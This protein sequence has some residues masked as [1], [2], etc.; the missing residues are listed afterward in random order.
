MATI[1]NRMK[2]ALVIT[3]KGYTYPLISPGGTAEI[4]DE[5]ARDWMSRANILTASGVD[6]DLST[7]EVKF[8]DLHWR[9]AITQAE[10]MEDLDALA[11]LHA[12]E[13]RP[14]VREVI[15]NRM[16]TLRG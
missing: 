14:K 10:T 5:H 4:T 8:M 7:E 9:A 13:T 1:R 11:E 2:Q 15:E 12:A 6:V 16:E 3:G